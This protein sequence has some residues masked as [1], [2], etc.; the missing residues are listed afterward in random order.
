MK[1]IQKYFERQ[2]NEKRLRE[3]DIHLFDKYCI[4]WK[5]DMKKLI[6]IFF[7]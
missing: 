5:K 6:I 1:R 4:K 2:R 3:L 7:C